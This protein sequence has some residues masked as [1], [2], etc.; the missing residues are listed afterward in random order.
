MKKIR[1]ADATLRENTLLSFK[2][3]LDIARQLESV[4]VDVIETAALT[5]DRSQELLLQSLAQSIRGSVVCAVAG[6]SIASIDKTFEL[7]SAAAKPRLK[8]M[9]PLSAALMEYNCHKKP[10][11]MLELIEEL[12]S[13]AASLCEDV[14]FAAVDATRTDEAFFVQACETALKAGA[15]TITICDTAGVALPGEMEDMVK[16]LL[17]DVPGM[18]DASIGVECSRKLHMSVGAVTCA[19]DAGALEAKTI[20]YD[21]DLPLFQAVVDVLQAR[22]DSFGMDFRLDV[23]KAPSVGEMVRKCTEVISRDDHPFTRELGKKNINIGSLTA[24]SSIGDLNNEL[25][26]L[27]YELNDENKIAVYDAFRELVS[28]KT[29]GTMELEALV[30][31]TAY[32]VPSTFRLKNFVSNSGSC[33]PSTANIILE[34]DGKEIQAVGTGNGPIDAAIATINNIVGTGYEL[35]D[36]Q[37]SAVT[38]GGD[39]LGNCL[40]KIRSGGKLYSGSH[41]ST[42]IVEAS[43]Q[44]YLSAINKIVYEEK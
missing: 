34:K 2:D 41:A 31:T 22:G 23:L 4:K 16:K 24:E 21:G 36:F 18:T 26:K 38:E 7:L 11:K 28:K 33:F 19:F 27:G 9:A 20:A 13:H 14:E 6:L 12:V 30:A 5:G 17:T 40:V 42:D 37:I 39:A 10:Q 35:E 3:K 25:R 29:V 8:I 32:R 44:A 43:I 1:I 15:T